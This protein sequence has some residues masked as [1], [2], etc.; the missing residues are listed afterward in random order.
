MPSYSPEVV[1]ISGESDQRQNGIPSPLND[2]LFADVGGA[3][4]TYLLIDPTLRRKVTGIFD[5]DCV[6]VPIACL[7]NGAAAKEQQEVAPYLVDLTF[8]TEMPPRFHRDFFARHWGQGT[9]IL[10]TST[11]SLDTLKRH[12]RKFTKLRREDDPRWFFFR[13]WDPAVASIYFR[14]IQNDAMRAAQWFGRGLIDGYVVEENKGRNVAVFRGEA[15]TNFETN[16]VLPP[17]ILTSEE[18]KPFRK[19][20]LERHIAHMAQLLKSDFSDELKAYS[21]ETITRR[22]CPAILRF[23]EF[24][25]SRREHLYVI[26]AWAMFF[27]PDFDTKDRTG[28]LQAICSSAGPEVSRFAALKARMA[29]LGS[30]G[31]SA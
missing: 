9:G 7:F 11:A 15:A 27:G 30:E 22:I 21:P 6:D 29:Q 16:K 2:L 25:F 17:V 26:A 23:M 31:A 24:G 5:L 12:F 3:K 13:F 14:I 10:V 8:E 20:A 4:R 1:S 19:T 28:G 18:L